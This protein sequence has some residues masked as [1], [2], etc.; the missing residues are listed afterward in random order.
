MNDT[1]KAK[2]Q[3]VAELAALRQRVARLEA[4]AAADKRTEPRLRRYASAVQMSSDSIVIT[5][6]TGQIIEVNETTLRLY[7]SDDPADLIGQSAFELIA[8]EDR[9]RALAGMTETLEKGL[10]RNREYRIICKD[11]RTMPVEMSVGIMRD[12]E[13]NPTGFVGISRDVTERKQ[14]EAALRQSEQYFRALIENALDMI[15]VVDGEGVIRYVS[16]AGERVLGYPAVEAVG[17]AGFGFVHP[18]D[19]GR[20]RRAFAQLIEQPGVPLHLEYR[21]RHK[22]GSWRVLEAVGRSLLHDPL[23]AGI[24][25]NTRDITERKRVE[26]ALRTSEARYRSLF[27]TANDAIATFT[28]DGV[29]TAV[30]RGAERLLGWARAELIGQ[31]VRRVATPG[32]V[33]LAEDR[34]RQW[35]AG[36]KLRSMF[37]AELIRKDGSVVPVEARTRHM[38][39]PDGTVV[40]YQGIYRDVTERK[41]TE[42]ELR[43]AKE[44]AEAGDRAKSE[45]LATMS[46]ELRTPL[47]II[48]GYTGM[49][50]KDGRPRLGTTQAELVRRIERSG[51]ELLELIS[52]VLDVSRLEAGRLPVEVRE[53][54][55]AALLQEVEMETQEVRQQSALAFRWQ[56]EEP[57]PSLHTD[58]GKLK[59]VLKNL[60]GNAVKFTPAGRITVAARK[61]GE[62]VEVCVSDTG[63]GIPAEALGVIFEP[64]RQVHDSVTTRTGGTGL[65]LYIV[66]RL[67]EL[68]GGT[69][70]VESKLGQGSTFRIWI[71]LRSPR[72]TTPERVRHGEERPRRTGEDNPAAFPVPPSPPVK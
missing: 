34:A 64:F 65:G 55:A 44:A 35:R 20:V 12:A 22:D 3:L 39:A 69:I 58:A 26:E 15:T 32:S 50:L 11:G 45:F 56:L 37:E 63:R 2:P 21:V 61:R 14:A 16:P 24:I 46:H 1:D 28:L 6:L 30:N 10:V 48:L 8:P 31:H 59:V 68:V 13:G 51:R 43:Q 19:L 7:G 41:R 42:Q 36:E 5:D 54:S 38:R 47:S 23:V 33:A 71:P 29:I 18:E 72:A 9:E 40:G 67:L 53:V 49:L 27:E 62:G 70:E 17:T 66:K 57:L 60:I 25:A 4:Q 52:S